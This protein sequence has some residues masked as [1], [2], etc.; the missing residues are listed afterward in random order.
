MSERELPYS[1]KTVRRS[2]AQTTFPLPPSTLEHAEILLKIH[3]TLFYLFSAWVLLHGDSGRFTLS[4]FRLPDILL[5]GLEGALCSINGKEL[6][7]FTQSAN[8][9]DAAHG[10]HS[11]PACFSVV[12]SRE[13][14]RERDESAKRQNYRASFPLVSESL[15]NSGQTL[16][17][18]HTIRTR[19]PRRPYKPSSFRVGL[20]NSRRGVYHFETDELVSRA[21]NAHR[22]RP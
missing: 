13:R 15:H 9:V 8:N 21:A 20:M 6:A 14:E 17:D 4:G 22:R 11:V 3:Y 7:L 10:A 2:A 16:V 19:R 5:V 12:S 1:E 18:A